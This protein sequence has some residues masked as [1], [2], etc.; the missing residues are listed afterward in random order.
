MPR[1]LSI[2]LV[3]VLFAGCRHVTSHSDF[4]LELRDVSRTAV[5]SRGNRVLDEGVRGP[6]AYVSVED[7][8]VRFA[9]R[10][11]A[12]VSEVFDCV[13]EGCRQLRIRG[14]Q[15]LLQDGQ[16]LASP[17]PLDAKGLLAGH[18]TPS[19]SL[20]F[21][22]K[23]DLDS[24]VVSESKFTYFTAD[25]QHTV[26]RS[27]IERKSLPISIVTDWSNVQEITA[28][29]HGN[30][31]LGWSSLIASFPLVIYGAYSLIGA[32]Q[33]ATSN[34]PGDPAELRNKAI[35]GGA[36]LVPGVVLNLLGWK[37][38]SSDRVT[39]WKHGSPPPE[40]PK[41]ETLGSR[42]VEEKKFSVCGCVTG[43]CF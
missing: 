32:A 28:E 1:P 16:R 19:G 4:Q 37:N 41:D 12:L 27:T 36:V 30:K 34:D 6:S 22:D 39:V 20:R 33:Q 3:A 21:S 7:W 13:E 42:R 17:V 38:I 15:W 14:T 5:V 18:A 31:L 25:A 29:A 40:R 9:R 35:I 8:R 11:G 10:P 26:T 43:M 2:L 24:R 23:L